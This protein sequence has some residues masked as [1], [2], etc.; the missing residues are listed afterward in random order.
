MFLLLL[1]LLITS[2]TQQLTPEMI[3]YEKIVSKVKEQEK[4]TKLPL[5]VK[6]TCQKIATGETLYRVYLDKPTIDMYDVEA[7]IVHNKETTDAYP[8]SGIL[9]KPL[10]LLVKKTDQSVKGLI[11]GGYLDAKVKTTDLTFKIYLR[12]HDQDQ[13]E[14]T[15]YYEYNY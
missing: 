2:C 8:S 9:E 6:V 15:S 1:V 12:Y 3:K 4:F 13:K 11:L 10:D 5:T 7:L 14:I